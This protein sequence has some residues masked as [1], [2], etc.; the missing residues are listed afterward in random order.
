MNQFPG[1]VHFIFVDRIKNRM[2]APAITP[3]HGQEF[4]SLL[5]PTRQKKF[6]EDMVSVIKQKVWELCYQSQI[7]LSKGY[8]SMLVKVFEWLD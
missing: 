5:D 6:S 8:N 4:V 2:I 3:L 7:H 1:L